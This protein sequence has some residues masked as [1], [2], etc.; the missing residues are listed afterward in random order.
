MIPLGFELVSLAPPTLLRQHLSL[1][2]LSAGF[3]LRAAYQLGLHVK[4]RVP[5]PEDEFEARLILDRER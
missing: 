4:R 2:V 3:A 5:L 1:P